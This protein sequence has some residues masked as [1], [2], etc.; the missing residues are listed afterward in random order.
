MSVSADVVGKVRPPN[1]VDAF[2]NNSV[3]FRSLGM[4]STRRRCHH[5]DGE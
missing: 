3:A 2:L 5:I 1:V 4:P